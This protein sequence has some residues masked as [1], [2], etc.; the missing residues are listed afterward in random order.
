MADDGAR[1]VSGFVASD[2]EALIGAMLEH[3]YRPV[4]LEELDPQ[5]SDMFLRH[6][7]DLS[8]E[9]ALQIAHRE[10]ALGVFS[11]FYFLVS[12]RFYNLA[13]SRGREALCE[14]RALGHDIGLHFDTTQ[15]SGS[16]DEIEDRAGDECTILE[17]LSGG[18]VRSLSFHRPAAEL[19]NREGGYAGRRHTY[20][21]AFFQ[22][23][24]YVSDSNGDWHHGHPLEHAAVQEGRAIQLLTHPIWWCSDQPRS[25][26]ATIQ[27]FRAE[28]IGTLTEDLAGTVKAYRDV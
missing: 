16:V 5:R 18:A 15:Y 13:S 11:T 23:I 12:T 9:H 28:R 21:P 2:Y 1:P 6:D 3:G 27:L 7:V 10:W 24:A 14:I 22:S 8:I 20:E 25:A 26:A 19:L 17:H 4:R